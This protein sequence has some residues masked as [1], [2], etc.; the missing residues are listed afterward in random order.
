MTPIPTRQ[1]V[2]LLGNS[3]LGITLMA[4]ICAHLDLKDPRFTAIGKAC[5]DADGKVEV[6]ALIAGVEVPLI[7][8]LESILE[9]L[10]RQVDVKASEKAL[11]MVTA[12]RLDSLQE[13]LANAESSIRDALVKVGAV[14]PERG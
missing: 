3:A 9:R 13:V 5:Q 12:A 2:P 7:P 10:E 4:A 8:A 1:S 14:Y 11:E 6:S